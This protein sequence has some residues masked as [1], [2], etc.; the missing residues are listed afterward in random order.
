M[1]T[2]LKDDQASRRDKLRQG[3]MTL[4][5]TLL[6][7][8]SDVFPECTYTAET[9]DFFRT[10]VKGREA[11]EEQFIRLCRELFDKNERGLSER[12]GEALFKIAES[13]QILRPIDLR[14]K[15][16]DPEF[17]EESKANL[18]KFV[19]SLDSYSKLYF[20]VPGSRNE[21]PETIK[22]DL[23]TDVLSRDLD[24]VNLGQGF[25]GGPTAK[26]SDVLQ[27]IGGL[28]AM[29]SKPDSAPMDLSTMMSILAKL[30]SDKG[31]LDAEALLKELGAALPSELREEL[32]K[33]MKLVTENLCA[34]AASADS[35]AEDARASKRQRA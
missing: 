26:A 8:I 12:D 33:V 10:L 18:W 30:Q 21:S 27:S 32:P 5:E 20:S 23:S 1:T 7:S 19:A 34:G 17:C 16:G 11:F 25:A 35:S 13:I 15:W 28:A 14:A 4:V 24:I 2:S 3:F 6:A 29:F 31:S 22:G 9:L